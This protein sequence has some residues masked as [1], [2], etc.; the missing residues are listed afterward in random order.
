[1]LLCFHSCILGLAHGCGLFQRMFYQFYYYLYFVIVTICLFHVIWDLF[2]RSGLSSFVLMMSGDTSPF[3]SFIDFGTCP[4]GWFSQ[5][6]VLIAY[7]LYLVIITLCL[8]HVV[9]DRS[10]GAIFP[11]NCI[12][13]LYCLC[14]MIITLC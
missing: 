10:R 6:I 11:R 13:C 14:R 2:P 7:C 5:E 12:H 4:C 8:F 3:G 1:L 9:W